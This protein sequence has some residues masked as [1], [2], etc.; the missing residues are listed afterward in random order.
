[1][2]ETADLAGAAIIGL[3]ANLEEPEKMIRTAV[4]R[5]AKTPGLKF[6]ACSSLYLTEPQGGPKIQNWYHN[7]VVFFESALTPQE[8]MGCLLSLEIALGRCPSKRPNT[9]RLIDLDFLAFGTLVLD[10]SPYL[11]LPHPRLHQRLFTLTPLAEVYPGWC[12]SILGRTAAELLASLNPVGQG[13]EKI[14]NGFS[15]SL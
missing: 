9:P 10:E 2:F 1:M 4:A 12:H 11:I 15:P 7:A 13:L 3:G 6:L 8:L 5:L 14:S